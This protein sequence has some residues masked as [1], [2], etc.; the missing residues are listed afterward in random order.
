MTRYSSEMEIFDL[1]QF[2]EDLTTFAAKYL[3]EKTED[4]FFLECH[5]R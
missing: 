3:K 2:L 1:I 4:S 5:A